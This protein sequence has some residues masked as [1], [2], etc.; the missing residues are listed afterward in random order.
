MRYAVKSVEEVLK[1]YDYLPGAIAVKLTG[2]RDEDLEQIARIKL[3]QSYGHFDGSSHP[4]TFYFNT[5]RVA[6]IDELR[7]RTLRKHR[8]GVELDEAWQMQDESQ[9]PERMVRHWV[10]EDVTRKL[11]ATLPTERMKKI[12]QYHFFDE[13]KGK[14]IARKLGVSEATVTLDRQK[15]L[16]LMK[17]Q[18]AKR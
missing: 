15:A 10:L 17:G 5:A 4:R 1:A 3:F 12:I 8:E 9:N 16:R 13:L 18:M 11:I 6:M 14:D 7:R 2:H